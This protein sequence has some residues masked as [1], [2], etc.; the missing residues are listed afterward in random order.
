M[1]TYRNSAHS[2]ELT[3]MDDLLSCYSRYRSH[4][5]LKLQFLNFSIHLHW[6]PLGLEAGLLVNTFIDL[7]TVYPEEYQWDFWSYQLF[8]YKMHTKPSPSSTVLQTSLRVVN[9]YF[10]LW[11]KMPVSDVF[12]DTEFKYVSRMSLSPTAFM[13]HQTAWKHKPTYVSHWGL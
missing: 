9:K 10:V 12:L 6:G 5:V 7:K 1:M 2:N 4:D 13:L 8:M 11:G 3:I